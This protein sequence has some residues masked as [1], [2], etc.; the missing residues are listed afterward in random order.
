[1]TVI[2]R[3]LA[4]VWCLAVFGLGFGIVRQTMMIGGLDPLNTA[5]GLTISFVA[6]WLVSSTILSFI[7]S[8][9]FLAIHRIIEG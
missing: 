7:G 3:V 4:V 1:M 9:S 6:V 8:I 2:F 5:S